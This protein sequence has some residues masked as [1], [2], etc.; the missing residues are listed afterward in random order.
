MFI[1][2]GKLSTPTPTM[3][4]TLWDVEYH[5]L[6]FRDAVMG[7]QSSNGSLAA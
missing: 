4:V 6:A 5:H 1:T 7:S 2:P 3:A